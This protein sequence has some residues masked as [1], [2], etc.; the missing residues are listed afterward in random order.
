MKFLDDLKA[1]EVAIAER[2][3][4]LSV[5]TLEDPNYPV[6]PLLIALGWV[7][8]KRSDPT[9]TYEAYGDSKTFTEVLKDLGLEEEAEEVKPAPRKR[10]K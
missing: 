1:N 8:A 5:T 7:I 3:A 2:K 4:G 9:L 10:G 6:A